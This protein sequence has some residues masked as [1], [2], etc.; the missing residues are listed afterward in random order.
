MWKSVE[1]SPGYYGCRLATD[2]QA[3]HSYNY[4][5]LSKYGGKGPHTFWQRGSSP[6]QQ[7][8]DAMPESLSLASQNWNAC[9]GDVQDEWPFNTKCC[10][11]ANTKAVAKNDYICSAP[12]AVT[13]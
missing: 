10:G 6:A 9:Y 12:T 3:D 8:E 4:I 2:N 7:F 5:D 11:K 1:G 13:V